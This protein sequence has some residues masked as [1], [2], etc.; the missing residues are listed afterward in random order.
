[1]S[2]LRHRLLG[3]LL[4]G[5]VLVSLTAAGATWYWAQREMSE[6]LDYQLRQQALSLADKAYLLGSVAV[7][8]PDPEQHIVTQLWDRRGNLRYQSH[9]GVVLARPE[10]YGYASVRGGDRDWRIYATELGPWIVQLAQP[11][12]I[13]ADIATTA[14]LR[15]LYPTLAVLPLLALIIWWAVGRVL[16]PLSG[17]ARTLA[18]REPAALE[19][20]A[21][22]GL[23]QE[24]GLLADALN[25]LVARQR[26]LLARQQEFMADAAHELR[27]PLTA[28]RLQLQLLERAPD[29]ASRDASLSELRRGIERSSVLIE[30]LLS[31]A[32]LDA[33]AV[34]TRQPVDLTEVLQRAANEVTMLAQAR[35]AFVEV[36]AEG[37]MQVAGDE[38]SLLALV[39]NLLENA[40]RH[41]PDGGRVHATLERARHAVRLVVM[42]QGPGIPLAERSR[43]FERFH[44]VPG[45]TTPGSGLGLAIVR[46]VAD[47]HGAT[48]RIDDAPGG[49]TL[50]EVDFPPAEEDRA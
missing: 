48:V 20:L 11:L 44:R 15:M 5:A 33:Q 19:P 46:R 35:Q 4:L 7:V 8:E 34:E 49:G 21:T 37:P 36:V 47:L 29:T 22:D 43:V 12:A 3:L 27:T 30:R 1:M 10:R 38:R 23:P 39:V 14:A 25:D 28:L 17:L 18:L 13:R 24:V 31:V 26:E 16:A 2:S 40:L 6:L 41:G 50:V 45:T 9:Q 32:R 42:D